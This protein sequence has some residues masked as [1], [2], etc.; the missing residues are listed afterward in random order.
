MSKKSKEKFGKIVYFDEQA[1]VDL[2]ELEKEGMESVVIK[3]LN[4]TAAQVEAGAS[5]NKGIFNFARLKLSGNASHQKNNIIETQITSTLISSFMDII[6]TNQKITKLEDHQL[7]IPKDSSA[8]F[9]NLVPILHMIDDINKLNTLSAEDKENF[10]G[11]NIKGIEDTLDSLSGYYDLLCI[12][13]NGKK[14]IVRF[15]IAG[16]RNNYNLNDLTK[17]DLTLFGVKVGESL[18][19]N[20]EFEHQIDNMTTPHNTTK[21]GLDFD[22]EQTTQ[23]TYEII[24][25]ILAG[26]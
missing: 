12:C 9:R 3:K 26:V 19:T 21:T 5:V 7:I 22:E 16:L 14:K 6:K 2:L 13:K 24:D 1:A 8:Y 10:S 23:I 15:N 17:M 11:I 25:V 18:D 4:E 20:L